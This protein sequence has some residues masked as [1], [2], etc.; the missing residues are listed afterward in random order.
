MYAEPTTLTGSIG[1]YG[2][3]PNFSGILGKIGVTTDIVKTNTYSDLGD[4]LRPMR[5]DE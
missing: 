1:V 3:F 2:M 4:D 5:E